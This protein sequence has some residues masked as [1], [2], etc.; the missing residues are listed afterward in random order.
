MFNLF[1]KYIIN[2][3]KEN[4]NIIILDIFKLYDLSPSIFSSNNINNVLIFFSIICDYIQ[5]NLWDKVY[6]LFIYLYSQIEQTLI[7][8]IK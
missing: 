2:K 5:L 4:I 3:D 7:I 6:D 8:Y 1:E